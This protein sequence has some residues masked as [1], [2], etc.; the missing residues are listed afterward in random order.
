M[1]LLSNTVRIRN[2]HKNFEQRQAEGG[3]GRPSRLV[4]LISLLDVHLFLLYA[5]GPPEVA[6]YFF[7]TLFNAH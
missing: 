7:S 1:R 4:A 2:K 3:S 6:N 5:L